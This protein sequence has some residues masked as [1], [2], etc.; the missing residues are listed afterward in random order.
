MIQDIVAQIKSVQ[1]K[2]E[3]AGGATL[4]DPTRAA[5]ANAYE[6]LVAALEAHAPD[7]AVLPLITKETASTKHHVRS[8]SWTTTPTP[9]PN[10]TPNPD[11]NPN[12]NSALNQ[13][14]L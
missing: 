5:P 1:I 13:P 8:L 12:P 11:P 2:T 7:D 6:R 9:T 3:G 4:L 10:P 14:E